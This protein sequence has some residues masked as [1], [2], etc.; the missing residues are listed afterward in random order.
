MST[1]LSTKVLIPAALSLGLLILIL[2]I[3]NSGKDQFLAPETEGPK[4]DDE[5]VEL[6]GNGRGKLSQETT[7]D[8]YSKDVISGVQSNQ[9]A[10]LEGE[11]S[12]S[13]TS[14]D[15]EE[16]LI[17]RQLTKA[18]IADEYSSNGDGT[19]TEAN[20]RRYA[21]ERY[22]RRRDLNGNG[23]LDGFEL[24]AISQHQG[25]GDEE[26]SSAANNLREL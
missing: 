13:S 15:F 23:K 6:K 3:T 26:V 10:E 7:D 22:L 5:L 12:D 17:Q 4:I 24:R 8:S 16:A 14:A 20:F 19:L 25:D 2:A 18:K 9:Q 21:E 1:K 11:Q